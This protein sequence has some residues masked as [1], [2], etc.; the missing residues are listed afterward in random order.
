MSKAQMIVAEIVFNVEDGEYKDVVKKGLMMA[1]LVSLEFIQQQMKATITQQNKQ[2]N[3][4]TNKNEMKRNEM[5]VVMAIPFSQHMLMPSVHLYHGMSNSSQ[6]VEQ[7]LHVLSSL[8]LIKMTLQH[9]K[10][11]M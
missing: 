1:N 3:K 5:Y 11:M 9:G 6:D 2:I 4:Q 10:C 7:I 8:G